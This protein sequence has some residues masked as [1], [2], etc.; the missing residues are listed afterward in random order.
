MIKLSYS[1]DIRNNN[2]Y[3]GFHT[4]TF[5]CG[6]DVKQDKDSFLFPCLVL[7]KQQAIEL[8]DALDTAIKESENVEGIF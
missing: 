4:P 6:W 8:R 3:L 2:R 1:T 7:T 5:S